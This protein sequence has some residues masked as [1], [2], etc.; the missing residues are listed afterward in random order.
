MKDACETFFN[1]SVNKIKD[2]WKLLDYVNNKHAI[3][4][5]TTSTSFPYEYNLFFSS[6]AER[7]INNSPNMDRKVF[8]LLY[9]VK[10][11]CCNFFLLPATSDGIARIIHY[12]TFS[13]KDNCY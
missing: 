5:K 6:I 8:D 7:L 10:I 1:M 2:C 12:N 4:N 9:T 13:E 11:P 3:N